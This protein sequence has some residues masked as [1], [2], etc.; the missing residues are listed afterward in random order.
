MTWILAFVTVLVLWSMA[1]A[2][3][4]EVRSL[5]AGPDSADRLL[6]EVGVRRVA[7][8]GREVLLAEASATRM[9]SRGP[10]PRRHPFRPAAR[11]G[12]C[13]R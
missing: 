5:K 12:A 2:C 8:T 7:G 6:A 4:R 1:V 3:Y 11:P 10:A 13:A 9:L